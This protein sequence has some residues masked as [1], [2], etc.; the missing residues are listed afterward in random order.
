MN[1]DPRF[2]RSQARL[3]DA[4]L[5]LASADAP[6]T[7]TVT[8]LA[9]EAGV[10]RSTVYEH[11]ESPEQLLR[12]AIVTELDHVFDQITP[13]AK[14]NGS[15]VEAV[16]ALLVY[17]ETRSDL[18]SR[19]DDSTGAVIV[20]AFTSYFAFNMIRRVEDREIIFPD[21]SLPLIDTE[22]LPLAVRGICDAYVRVYSAWLAQPEPRDPELAFKLIKLVTPSWWPFRLD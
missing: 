14:K 7:I 20:E 8:D 2:I 3:H 13:I 6:A 18:Y 5:R 9:K 17:L 16:Q 1:T 15:Q 10:H 19:M 12:Q 11:A 21:D 4:I 22:L